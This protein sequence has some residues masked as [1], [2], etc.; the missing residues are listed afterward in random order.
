[1]ISVCEVCKKRVKIGELGR[2]VICCNV[3]ERI[4]ELAAK[5]LEDLEDYE[6]ESFSVGSKLRGSAKAVQNFLKTEL[7]IDDE[8][9]FKRN[10]NREFARKIREKSGKNFKPN[11]DVRVIV[12]LEDLRID[13]EIQP[14]YIFGRY[15]KRVRY[16][17]QTRWLCSF[18]KG[19]GCEACNF[20][21]KKYLSVEDIIITPALE[22]F[23]GENAFLHGSGREDVDARML[24]N[25]RPFVLEVVK[26]KKRKVD[27]K[28]LE[29]KINEGSGAVEVKLLGYATHK[30]VERIKSAS[31][32]KRYRAL[33]VFEKE[34]DER[35]LKDAL[36]KLKTVIHQRTPKRVE[37]RRAD[38]VRVK[39]V[40]DTKLL[41][42]RG[43][44]AVIEIEAEGGLYIK[45][46]VS[47]DEGRTKPSLAE[48]IGVNCYVDKLDVVWIYDAT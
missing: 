43:N 19:R 6:F 46:L 21:G 14:V 9:N 26:P 10:F 2:C 35:T 15:K 29:R 18:C 20:T 27:L 11:G 38:K 3:F 42:H 41:L 5:V 37:H 47:G 44:K 40:Y 7:G 4:E 25:G 39:R 30:D 23:E 13:Y 12:D 32:K 34:V 8:L 45:E 48:L 16:L 28:E 22:V 24:G 17:A 36:E 1:M 31:Y 33:V